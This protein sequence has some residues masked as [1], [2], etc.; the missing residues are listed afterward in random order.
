M[1]GSRA[2]YLDWGRDRCTGC[3]RS[4]ARPH[5]WHATGLI[6]HAGQ[7]S[8]L[9]AAQQCLASGAYCHSD[10]V[11]WDARFCLEVSSRSSY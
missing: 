4:A 3:G 11:N 8:T 10:S 9:A 1:S 7:R 2:A 6:V 5:R